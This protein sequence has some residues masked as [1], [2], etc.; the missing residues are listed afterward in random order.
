MPHFEYQ[1]RD[2]SGGLQ[3]G[4]LEEV[5]LQS[6]VEALQARRWLVLDIS[7]VDD[8]TAGRG[9]GLG[10]WLPVRA[11]DVEMSL[12]QI[13]VM[14][15]SGMPLLDATR[16]LH[17]HAERKGLYAAWK[18]VSEDVLEGASM[19]MAMQAQKLFPPVALYL[20]KIGEQTGELDNTLRR[21]ADI[22]R[23]QRQLRTKILTALAYP[24]VVFL[25]GVAVALFMVFN[26]IPQIRQFL[27]ALNRDL[28]AMTQLL[29][30]VTNFANEHVRWLGGAAAALLALSICLWI[31]P[32]S[33]YWID[34]WM[35][36]IP[37]IGLVFRTSAAASFC[38]N[39]Q[40]LIQ[41]GVS[42]LD[43]LKSVEELIGNRRLQEQLAATRA[44]VLEG[45][46]LA[47]AVRLRAGFTPMLPRILA[48]GESSGR[49]EEVLGESADYY[50]E[51]LHQLIGRL[52]A[53]VEPVML[54]VV[55][56][57]VG[58]VYIAFFMALFAA[59]G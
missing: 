3:A 43:G 59:A 41:S 29:V 27:D 18:Q 35:L 21:A 14:L 47:D 34:R 25:A 56:S 28:P 24:S 13:S 16:L 17:E 15:R 6:A 38:R 22:V 4:M 48:I 39:L 57:I 23:Q 49:L 8:S 32:A 40:T 5:S 33:R 36:R 11:I 1:A 53:L 7:A 42:L 45:S 44:M 50:E 20:T 19:A 26:V 31:W 9:K 46:S 58:F 30:D 55:G 51:Q 37:I 12:R 54:L 52:S 10:W 2:R